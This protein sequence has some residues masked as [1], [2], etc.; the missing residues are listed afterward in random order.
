MLGT[1]ASPAAAYQPLAALTGPLHVWSL[2][3]ELK[4]LNY[5]CSQAANKTGLSARG[6]KSNRPGRT[7]SGTH[8]GGHIWKWLKLFQVI[9]GCSKSLL[10]FLKLVT[11]GRHWSPLSYFWCCSGAGFAL[12]TSSHS[13]TIKQEVDICG[14]GGNCCQSSSGFRFPGGFISELCKGKQ[15]SDFQKRSPPPPAEVRCGSQKCNKAHSPRLG[16]TSQ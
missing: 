8:R 9:W 12:S 10:G 6:W 4:R 7:V 14:N 13:C 16:L 2:P 5:G 15:A 1:R 3:I 11:E